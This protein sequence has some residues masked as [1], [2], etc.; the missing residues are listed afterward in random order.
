MAIFHVPFGP[1]PETETTGTTAGHNF[2]RRT[3][4]SPTHSRLIFLRPAASPKLF[5]EAGEEWKGKVVTPSPPDYIIEVRVL[6]CSKVGHGC[7]PQSA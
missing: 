1:E 5:H 2:C 4:Q 3:H 6:N 7:G